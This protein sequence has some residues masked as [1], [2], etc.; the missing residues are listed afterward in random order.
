MLSL[1]SIGFDVIQGR[2]ELEKA[3]LRRVNDLDSFSFLSADVL[4]GDRVGQ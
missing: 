2:L 3:R 1:W 4:D